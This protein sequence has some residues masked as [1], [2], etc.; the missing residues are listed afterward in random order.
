MRWLLI[1]VLALAGILIL[2][3]LIGSLLPRRHV[4]SRS[5]AVGQPPEAV[6]NLITSPP[7]WRH[8]IKAYRELPQSNGHRI[9]QE[10]DD[11]GQTLTF[12]AMESVPPRRLVTR[13]A[14][15]K[16]PFGGTWTYE[17]TPGGSGCSLTITENGEVYNPLFRFVSQFILGHATRIDAY[18][19]DLKTK[20]S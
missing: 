18:L 13:I 2:V 6:W 5:V 17:V 4:V 7:T 14:D 16:L 8:A 15:A 10:T 11:L 19:R 20:L 9:W 1:T 12:E 3:I